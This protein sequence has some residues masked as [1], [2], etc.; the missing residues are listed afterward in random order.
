MK[1]ASVISIFPVED[2]IMIGNFITAGG[3]PKA[4]VP[5]VLPGSMVESWPRALAE[6][7]CSFLF[8][9]KKHSAM[10]EM[11]MVYFFAK[12]SSSANIVLTSVFTAGDNRQDHILP[13]N[14][15]D[16]ENGYL[17]RVFVACGPSFDKNDIAFFEVVIEFQAF[18]ILSFI[19]RFYLSA[20]RSDRGS[21]FVKRP[22]F[23]RY[24][25]RKKQLYLP[26]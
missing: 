19:S 2:G 9:R 26:V 20:L 5:E 12:A 8:C 18:S 7:G 25:K 17:Q 10:L 23:F 3:P 16:V 4:Y 1:N 14:V 15:L 22:C 6:T 24:R 21:L 11:P 13:G